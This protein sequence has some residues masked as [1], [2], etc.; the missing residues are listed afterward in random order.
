M[1]HIPALP[2][3]PA[4]TTI[5]TKVG[6][7]E[8]VRRLGWKGRS[9]GMTTPTDG[10]SKDIHAFRSP[11]HMSGDGRPVSSNRY[12]EM[13]VCYLALM[14]DDFDFRAD[15]S[16]FYYDDCRFIYTEC[17]SMKNASIPPY[18]T[19]AQASWF[20]RPDV[21]E[22]MRMAKLPWFGDQNEPRAFQEIIQLVI[23]GGFATMGCVDWYC[24]EIREWRLV[25]G[26]RYMSYRVGE[27]IDDNESSWRS[28]LKWN[29]QAVQ[30]L[31][32]LAASAGI[33]LEEN[34][35]HGNK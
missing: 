32:A 29:K 20:K 15:P 18:D 12:A 23:D 22:R 14:Y 24:Q 17:Q 2:A 27:L 30:Q 3:A 28:A 5:L 13:A 4:S 25:R 31:E 16:D 19:A 21:I 33:S 6:I 7:T 10:Q 11:I 9:E 1:V 8:A 26:V 35:V 34:H